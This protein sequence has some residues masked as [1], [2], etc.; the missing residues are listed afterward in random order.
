MNKLIVSATAMF[1][2]LL[3]GL[4]GASTWDIDP[5]HSVAG[6]SVRH[7]MVSKV[8]GEFGKVS[9][10]VNLDDKDISKSTVEATI[11]V[12]TVTTRD[13]KRDEHLKSGD[14]FDVAKFPTITFKSKRVQKAGAGKLKVVGDL[15]I[16]GV[17]KEV[18]LNVEGPNKEVK[19]PWGNTKSGASATTKI[20]R[21]D[22]GLTWNKSLDGGGV[23]V[24]DEVAITIDVE[25]LKK[26]K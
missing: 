10:T 24:G 7:L 16:H 23:V 19:D 8:P 12:S 18:T 15:T 22:F 11:D 20:D 2:L 3:P 4:A 17:T 14:F 25:L 5:A 1:A 26:D 6:F 21:K 13:P 9:G